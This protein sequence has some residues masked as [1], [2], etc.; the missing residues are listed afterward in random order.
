LITQIDPA[1]LRILNT[2]TVRNGDYVL[3]WMQSSHRT[4]ENPALHYAIERADH[5]HLPLIVY[6][7]LWQSYPEASLRHFRFMLEGLYE[8]SR[9]L[10]SLGIRLVLRTEPPDRGVVTL[11]DN[12]ALVVTD[13]GYLKVQQGWY[14]TVAAQC[15][16]PL[17]QVEGNVVVP[18]ETASQ[19]EEYAAATFRP[20]VTRLLDRF[21]QRLDTPLPERSSLGMDL[22]TLAGEP[23]DSLL[24]QI[25]VDRAVPVSAVLQGGSTE[26][27]RKFG[28]FLKT[29]LK[30]FADDRND[31]GGGGGSGMSPYL[32]FGQVSPVTLA[33][34]AQEQGGTGV[35]SFLEELIVRRE[36]AVNF[37][38]YND[39]YDSF[40][41]LPAWAR[42]TL[43]QHQGDQREYVYSP[44]ELEAA[45]THDPYWNAAQ[46]EMAKTGTMQGYMRMY[47]GKK[48]LEW[49]PS[50][51]EGYRTALYLNNRYEID[52]RDPNG[53]AGIA[54]CFG[55]HDRPWKER[56]IF[57]MVRYMNAAGLER[58]FA[59]DRYIGKVRQI[60]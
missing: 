18:V 50:P 29:R 46:Q 30:G 43:G 25:P 49:S 14:Q 35:P 60:P 57:G 26:A 4:E 9:S 19:K 52:G 15:R 21:L 51:Q 44:G 27:H 47:W 54:W 5:A 42:K 32:H 12:A 6:F 59:M 16:C 55:K 58:K 1:R 41:S 40:A 36:L 37:V 39:A 53:Y 24:A 34:Q 22:P 23:P 48:I 7:G 38:R 17:I 13:R 8:V 20:K 10:E 3:Y 56:E 2:A 45:G 28:Q 11:A 33:L 31:P